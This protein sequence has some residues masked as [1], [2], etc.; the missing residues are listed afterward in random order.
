[1]FFKYCDRYL[2]INSINNSINNKRT[3]LMQSSRLSTINLTVVIQRTHL[4]LSGGIVMVL[5]L[6]L[7][8]APLTGNMGPPATL[9]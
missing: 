7:H 5:G 8:E 1:M 6:R 9:L 2:S 4:V 3:H